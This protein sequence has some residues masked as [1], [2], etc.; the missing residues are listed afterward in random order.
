MLC[1]PVVTSR[2]LKNDTLNV[3]IHA[4]LVFSRPAILTMDMQ[5][6]MISAL[7]DIQRVPKAISSAQHLQ[8]FCRKT[9]LSQITRSMSW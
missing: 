5:S 6:R 3:I 9:C 4:F 8:F 1:Y 2:A 7:I